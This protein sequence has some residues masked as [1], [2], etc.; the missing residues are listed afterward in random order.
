MKATP[1]ASCGAA[2]GHIGYYAAAA[3]RYGAHPDDRYSYYG[4][5]VCAVMRQE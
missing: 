3:F 4:F 2:R 5:R 1:S